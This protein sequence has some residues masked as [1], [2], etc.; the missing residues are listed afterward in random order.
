MK[1]VGFSSSLWSEKLTN[2]VQVDEDGLP[3]PE[4]GE[5]VRSGVLRRE[6][7]FVSD[8]DGESKGRQALTSNAL[9]TNTKTSAF[10][11]DPIRRKLGIALGA[12]SLDLRGCET[13][14]RADLAI[15]AVLIL[16]TLAFTRADDMLA[17]YFSLRRSLSSCRP[18]CRFG[19]LFRF[20][21]PGKY[22]CPRGVLADPQQRSRRPILQ[23]KKNKQNY[24]RP[25]PSF[26]P[27]T[28]PP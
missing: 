27:V 7:C 2:E 4:R 6:G 5:G 26:P 18:I 21:R 22:N 8:G 20:F 9:G 16:A 11:C 13:P 1:E 17:L 15:F 24:P 14:R 28:S 23:N 12:S 10:R 25:Q 19:A 3:H